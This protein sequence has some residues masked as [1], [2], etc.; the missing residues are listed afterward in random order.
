M[1]CPSCGSDDAYVGLSSID[2]PNKTC[3]H[4]QGGAVSLNST[5]KAAPLVSSNP[6][7]VVP[8][9]VPSG[10]PWGGPP[11]P[12]PWGAQGTAPPNLSIRISRFL[13]RQNNVQVS[14]IASGDPGTPDK[15]VEIYFDIGNGDQLCTLSNPG[16]THISGVDA[17]GV[18]VYTTNW[19][20]LM[21]GVKPTDSFQLK[22]VIL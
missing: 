13:P 18:T 12:G 10:F 17:D 6:A 22:A 21:D 2:C 7:R 1:K 8:A 19:L 20:C 15:E 4:F 5:A 16:V 14:F 11:P 3:L 9:A